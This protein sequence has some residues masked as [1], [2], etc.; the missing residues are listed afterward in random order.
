MT[1][2]E[3]ATETLVEAAKDGGTEI[4]AGKLSVVSYFLTRIQDEIKT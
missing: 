2:T 4:D 1:S 3:K